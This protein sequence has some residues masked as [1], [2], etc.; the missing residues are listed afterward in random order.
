MA[1]P[2]EGRRRPRTTRSKSRP[3]KARK[4]AA[5][6]VRS[7]SAA[8]AEA[9]LQVSQAEYARWR[10]S[11]GLPGGTREGVRKAV[12]EQRIDLLPNG[13]IDRRAADRAW[14]ERSLP[15]VDSPA[16]ADS[17]AGAHLT[18]ARAERELVRKQ[19]DQFRLSQAL[20][21]SVPAAEIL[22]AA[23]EAH[24]LTYERLRNL[25]RRLGPVVAVCSDPAEC[26]R[27]LEREIEVA[28]AELARPLELIP[29][30]A[31][32]AAALART[33]GASSSDPTAY[34]PLPPAPPPRG[35]FGR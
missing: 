3:R 33:A 28:A 21:E 31:D 34:P 26:T 30:G 10:K 13:R 19:L 24:R 7:A 5:R 8:H 1:R 20:R 11:R 32:A 9:P 23:T 15:R 18:T 16:G 6:R 12:L 2:K 22:D 27:I 29:G 25:A 14:D 4:P 17:A 35:R